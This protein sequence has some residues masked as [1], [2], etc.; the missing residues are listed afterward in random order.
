MFFLIKLSVLELVK[1]NM[2]FLLRFFPLQSVQ[3]FSYLFAFFK[4]YII[5]V[6]VMHTAVKPRYGGFLRNWP[7]NMVVLP[8]GHIIANCFYIYYQKQKTILLATSQYVF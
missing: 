3:V 2:Q 6:F 4:A 1:S 7:K 5:V 8:V